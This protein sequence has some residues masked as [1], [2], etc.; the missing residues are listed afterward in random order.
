MK[1][2]RERRSRRHGKRLNRNQAEQDQIFE[3]FA[4]GNAVLRSTY[5]YHYKRSSLV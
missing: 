1:T 5:Y 3:H 4:R 2:L